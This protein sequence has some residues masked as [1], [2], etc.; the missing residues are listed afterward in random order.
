MKKIRAFLLVATVFLAMGTVASHAR[1]YDVGKSPPGIEKLYVTNFSSDLFNPATADISV[2][3]P[4]ECFTCFAVAIL[5]QSF[6]NLKAPGEYP[7]IRSDERLRCEQIIKEKHDVP[8]NEP[9]HI[10]KE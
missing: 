10:Q 2:N 9:A 8:P 6:N 4:G 7:A 5:P 1:D 3:E